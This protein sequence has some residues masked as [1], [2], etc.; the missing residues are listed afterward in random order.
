MP[1]MSWMENPELKKLH[2]KK[3]TIIK[4]LVSDTEGKPLTVAMPALMKANNQLKKE[5]MAFTQEETS[6]I[7]DLL[8]RNMS[9]GEKAKV[10]NIKKM[11]SSLK[12]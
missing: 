2:P 9:P 6:L 12:F 7:M 3:L 1:D 11:A 5:H 10:E 4:E 8:T